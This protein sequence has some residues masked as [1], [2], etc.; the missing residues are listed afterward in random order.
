MGGGST[1]FFPHALPSTMLSAEMNLPN[2]G[3]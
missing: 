3:S 2:A 1:L